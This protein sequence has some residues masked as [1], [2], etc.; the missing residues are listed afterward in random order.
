MEFEIT[1]H[2]KVLCKV[3]ILVNGLSA[4]TLVNGFSKARD[5]DVRFV[6]TMTVKC[7]FCSPVTAMIQYDFL[8]EYPEPID[9]IFYR[10]A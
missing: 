8:N 9:C 4:T 1:N 2:R 7:R 10:Q 3:N 6:K 5:M